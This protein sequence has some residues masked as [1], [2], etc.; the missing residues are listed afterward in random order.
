MDLLQL[1]EYKNLLH[2]YSLVEIE[3]SQFQD[4]VIMISGATGMI[5]SFLIDLLMYKNQYEHLH[6]TVIALGRNAEKSK[7]RFAE[8]WDSEFFRFYTCDINIPLRDIQTQVDYVLHAASNTHPLAYST[9]PIG[10]VTTN[11]IGTRNMLEYAAEHGAKQ[12][13]FASSV[14]VYGENRGDVETFDEKYCGYINCNTLR[15]GYPESKRAGEALCQAF[16]AQKNMDIVIPRLARTYGPTMLMS[17]SKAISQFIKK[18]LAQEDIVLKS[19]GNQL[20]SYTFVADAVMGILYCMLSGEC[21]MAYNIVGN[22]SDIT[23]KEL[24]GLIAEYAGKKVVFDLPSEE[25]RKGYS[26]ATKAIMNGERIAALNW[27][28]RFTIQTGIMKTMQILGKYYTAS[29]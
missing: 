27:K 1:D 26:T 21:G 23:L 20:Y 17:D 5:G 7:H 28:P 4:K 19:K 18:G 8:Y 10:T 14:E 2:D 24:A 13:V 12:F 9:D 15:A 25:E 11:I 22:G 6:C 29:I 3:W 16:I